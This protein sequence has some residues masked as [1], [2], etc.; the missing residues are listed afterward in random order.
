MS[1]MASMM[2]D[3][4]GAA[5]S[6]TVGDD[7]QFTAP[8]KEVAEKAPVPAKPRE[9]DGKFA[10]KKERH[11][12]PTMTD[13]ENAALR[14][15]DGEEAPAPAKAEE[16]ILPEG[17]VKVPTI[18]GENLPFKVHDA[19][20]E[21]EVPALKIQYTANGKERMDDI[22]QLVKMAQWGAYNQ[23]K[24]AR[25]QQATTQSAAVVQENTRLQQTIDQQNAEREWLLSKDE[26][27]LAA[28]EKYE[29]MNT[30]EAR[31]F[32]KAISIMHM[33]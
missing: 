6:E 24:E 3:V 32:H 33:S 21:L 8:V 10:K 15:E 29:A 4:V 20:G 14:A 13:E 26:N 18:A 16:V 7:A 22:P 12:D 19:E 25:F 28:R 5:V 2:A 31:L 17:M 9:E 11:V 23:E 30:P 1:D 27:Y